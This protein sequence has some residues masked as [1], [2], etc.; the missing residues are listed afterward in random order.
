MKHFGTSVSLC[1]APFFV[2][3]AYAYCRCAPETKAFP[4]PAAFSG[5]GQQAFFSGLHFVFSEVNLRDVLG[6]NTPRF[7]GNLILLSIVLVIVGVAVGLTIRRLLGRKQ[8]VVSQNE[9]TFT[10][11]VARCGLSGEEVSIL[12]AMA[13]RKNLQPLYPVFESLRVFEECVD[14]QV[15]YLV[16]NMLVDDEKK[17]R[18][19]YS[20]LRL[21]LGYMNLPSEYPLASTRNISIGQA[22]SIYAKSNNRPL[23]RK[24]S[25]MDNTAFY[26]TLKYTAGKEQPSPPL[27]GQTIRFAFARQNDGLY[28]IES[29][30]IKEDK[31]GILDVRH[32]LDLK[33]NQLRQ[34]VRIETSLPVRF[35]LVKTPDPEKSE[36]KPGELITAKLSDVSGGGLSFFFDRSLR[37]GDIVSLNF[38]LPGAS[39]AGITGKIVHLTLR[40][41]KTGKQ[42]KHHVQFVNIEAR[43]REKIISYI[44][45]KERRVNQWR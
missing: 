38:E 44:F 30:V 18:G 40:D 28:G 12:T 26:L 27:V 1:V 8:E 42:I 17:L 14:A 11:H 25:V 22:G 4:I 3:F 5:D 15:H 23:Y 24:V 10:D 9:K 7:A 37:L 6:W 29:T 32:T 2:F 21:K 41:L 43:K 45:E 33:R 16:D 36:V 20:E 34:H 31:A 19:I 35:R 13:K 39:C